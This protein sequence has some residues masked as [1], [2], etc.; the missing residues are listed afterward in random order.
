MA[1]QIQESEF[2]KILARMNR[3]GS[4]STS[5]LASEDGL[6]VAVA[7]TMSTHN[8]E[9]MAAMV[10][11]VKDF[12]EQACERLGLSQ[13]DEVSVVVDDRSRLIC[14]YFKAADHAF[15]LAIVAPPNVSYRHLTTSAIRELR[16]AWD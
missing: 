4:F 12:V 10:T 1:T 9:T 13:L 6:P 3:E 15:V 8:A 16:E 14:R 7:P 11:M 5:V 2:G